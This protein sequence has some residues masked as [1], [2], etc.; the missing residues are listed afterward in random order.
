MASSSGKMEAI[1]WWE[2]L[3]WAFDFE[4]D[5]IPKLCWDNQIFYSLLVEMF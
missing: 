3:L 4:L 5:Q 1:K 2:A